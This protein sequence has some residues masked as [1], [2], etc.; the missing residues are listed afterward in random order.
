MI[1]PK[2]I[3]SPS[4]NLSLCNDNFK[5]DKVDNISLNNNNTAIS[6]F[7]TK[8]KFI[9]SIASSSGNKKPKLETNKLFTFDIDSV[10]DSDSDDNIVLPDS[11]NISEPVKRELKR[12]S[13]ES[14]IAESI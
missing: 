2:N 12:K 4:L 6:K 11:N 9:E 8:R 13:D 1:E 5:S 7:T 10:F 3:S 14:T